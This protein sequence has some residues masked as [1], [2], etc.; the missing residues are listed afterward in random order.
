M[1]VMFDSISMIIFILFY[2]LFFAL[3]GMRLFGGS[4]EGVQYF[5][6]FVDASF[7]MLV[8]LTTANFPNIMLPAYE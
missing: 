7:S 2:V 6:S 5:S 1:F 8:L 4:V 3:L